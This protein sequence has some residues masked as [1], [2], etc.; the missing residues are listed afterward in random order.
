MSYA[1]TII[2]GSTVH[3][4]KVISYHH[5]IKAHPS[6]WFTPPPYNFA[7]NFAFNFDPSPLVKY[8]FAASFAFCTTLASSIVAG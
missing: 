5:I 6:S 7:Y 3:Q 2:S 1:Y 4:K 8:S